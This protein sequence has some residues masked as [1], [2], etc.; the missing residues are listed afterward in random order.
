MLPLGLIFM[1][2]GLLHIVARDI[3]WRVEQWIH[4]IGGNLVQRDP[5]WDDLNMIEGM[6]YILLG[7]IMLVLSLVV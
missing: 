1:V 2:W 4:Q 3:V 7:S 5:D 6:I